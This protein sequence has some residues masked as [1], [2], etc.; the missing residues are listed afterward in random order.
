MICILILCVFFSVSILNSTSL[1]LSYQLFKKIFNLTNYIN[2]LKITQ[3]VSFDTFFGSSFW[4]VLQCN[5]SPH[6]ATCRP[7]MHSFP[8]LSQQITPSVVCARLPAVLFYL[9]QVFYFNWNISGNIILCKFN[10]CNMLI[11]FLY[12]H[13]IATVTLA[14]TYITSYNYQ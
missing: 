6:I 14:N 2:Y 12:G 5:D 10:M 9:L 11:R 3:T 8:N 13:M 4:P 1:N 7:K